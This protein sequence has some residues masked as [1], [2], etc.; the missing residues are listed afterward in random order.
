MDERNKNL[1]LLPLT[2]G[3]VLPGMVFTMALES[4][5][6]QAAAEAA[7]AADGH[8]VLVPFIDG[9]YASVGVLA[10]VMERGDLPG[11][12]PAV[13]VRGVERARLGTAVPGTG[14][15]LW[16]EVEVLEEGAPTPESERAGPRVPGRPREH[17]AQP[18]RRPDRRAPGGGH[19][20]RAGWPTWRATPPTSPWPRRSQVLETLD[21]DGTAP[22]GHRLGPRGP[23]RPHPARADQDRRRRGDGEDPAR[24]PA[25]PPARVHPQGA[26]SDRGGRRRRSRRLPDQAGAAGPARGRPQGGGARDRQARADERAE[27]RARLDPHVA[28]HRVRGA[29]GRAVRGP[30]RRHRGVAHPRRG[31]RR[32]RGR[33]G[34]DPRA[35][36]RAQAPGRARAGPGV[37]SRCGGHP[38]PRRPARAWARRRWGVGGARPR[39]L[40]RPGGPRWCARRGRDPG[41]P[42]H[43]RRRPARAP[44]PGPAR[45]RDHEPGDRPR[46]GRQAGGRLP[47][48]PV[49]GA[50][51][52]ARPGPEPHLPRPLPRS[53]AGPV[54]GLFLAT[55]NVADT[56]P[57]AAARPDGGHPAGRLHRGREGGHRPAPSGRAPAGARRARSG[58]G[59]HHRRRAARP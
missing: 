41:P 33:E 55:A 49:L 19:R 27:P 42:P 6:A 40:L 13:A 16:V 34:P 53:R 39:A 57:R 36:G 37:R 52:G 56:D 46:R 30:P 7:E 25:A 3:V 54:Q 47:G 26:R 58:R 51:R 22:S 10:E 11:G 12:M 24:V 18:R 5:E 35:P 23:G 31:P 21:V 20:A 45:G 43:L 9:R 59:A 8:F 38:G 50:A 14:R 15:A 2:S 1:P 28:R 44:G 4:D 48:R 32:P 17:P 29:L